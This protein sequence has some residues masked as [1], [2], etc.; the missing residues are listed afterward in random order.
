MK[1]RPRA[2]GLGLRETPRWWLVEKR[3]LQ[4]KAKK[5]SSKWND[6]SKEKRVKHFYVAL[7]SPMQALSTQM[8][9]FLFLS[10]RPYLSCQRQKKRLLLRLRSLAPLAPLWLLASPN[11]NN[12]HHMVDA[13][14]FGW[15]IVCPSSHACII[16]P[17]HPPTHSSTPSKASMRGALLSTAVVALS[18]VLVRGGAS[19]DASNSGARLRATKSG[20][21]DVGLR[22]LHED[23]VK[24]QYQ[25]E[26]K[27]GRGVSGEEIK[28]LV[29]HQ[30]HA[31][32]GE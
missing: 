14:V 19:G 5:A 16:T 12:L 30:R 10:P 27:Y 17:T 15:F 13:A 24:E 1:E 11:K 8:F 18:L 7:Y 20:G 23:M 25:H 2:G 21:R 29:A 26:A 28:A 9:C 4:N 22:Q 6:I 3:L 32:P 31:H